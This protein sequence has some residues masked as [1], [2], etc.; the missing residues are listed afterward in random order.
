MYA[1]LVRAGAAARPATGQASGRRSDVRRPLAY[2]NR[3]A[4]SAIRL[5]RVV[6]WAGRSRLRRS[7][8]HVLFEPG[9]A[10]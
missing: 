2:R 7:A 3:N 6:G 8:G 9:A 1:D 10:V 4:V 5:A